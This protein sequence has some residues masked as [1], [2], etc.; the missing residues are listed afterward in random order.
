ML[1]SLLLESTLALFHLIARMSCIFL[2]LVYPIYSTYTLFTHQINPYYFSRKSNST[3]T[4][5]AFK[6]E[7]QMKWISYWTIYMCIIFVEYY[8]ESTLYYVVPFYY[9]LKC[10]LL[11]WLLL[12]KFNGALFIYQQYSRRVVEWYEPIIDPLIEQYI[13]KAYETLLFYL[14]IGKEKMKQFAM[15]LFYKNK[16]TVVEMLFQS[17]SQQ[18]SITTSSVQQ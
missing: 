2:G 7:L 5:S 8:F 4:A 17:P 1:L 11:L 13:E 15:Q 10:V 9:E 3:K 12:P 14:Q 6:E 16:N 18:P